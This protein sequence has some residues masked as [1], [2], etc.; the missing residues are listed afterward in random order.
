MTGDE[1]PAVTPDLP[2]EQR[3]QYCRLTSAMGRACQAIF[4][5]S[6]TTAVAFL[7]TGASPVMPI[8]AFGYYAALAIILNYIMAMTL[9]PSA[10]ILYH[11]RFESKSNCCFRAVCTNCTDLSL[12][13]V[14]GK[15]AQVLPGD[16]GVAAPA[17]ATAVAADGT[18][19][20]I[21]KGAPVENVSAVHKG[22]SSAKEPGE[23]FDLFTTVYIPAMTWMPYKASPWMKPVPIIF[24]VVLTIVFISHAVFASNLQPPSEEER[25]FSEGHMVRTQIN[26]DCVC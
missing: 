3:K 16:E 8:S 9:L 7:A 17:P 24:V 21:F 6:V 5:T 26:T 2:D 1:Y 23:G 22:C 25:W 11:R 18:P 12:M 13:M 15:S 14:G 4:N 20:I 10:V 19:A